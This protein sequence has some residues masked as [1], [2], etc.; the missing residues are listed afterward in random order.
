ML[1]MTYVHWLASL[2]NPNTWMCVCV[3]VHTCICVYV[4]AAYLV[5]FGRRK[6]HVEDP[7]PASNH[8]CGDCV[9]QSDHQEAKVTKRGQKN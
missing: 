9:S 4:Y 6:D 7:C 8:S 2:F 1:L 3:C 5:D